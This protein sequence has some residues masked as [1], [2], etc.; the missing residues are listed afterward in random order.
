MTLPFATYIFDLDGTLL[1]TLPDLVVN[2]NTALSQ[3]GF[4]ARTESDI[5]WFIGDGLKALITRC[6]PPGT[7]DDMIEQVLS[8]WKEL[9]PTVGVALAKPYDGIPELLIALQRSGAKLGV[10]SNKF[11]AGVVGL[12]EDHFPG[13]F[14]VVHGEGP[15]IPRKPDPTGLLTTIDELGAEH[16]TTV[17]IGDSPTDVRVAI[18]AGI[19][20][21]AVAWGYHPA[22]ELRDTAAL[23]VVT[24]P[25][26]I[27]EVH[28]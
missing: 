9:Y 4:P 14:T 16:G 6:V 5:H 20:S 7:S 15:S 28:P 21:I 24:D 1:D 26:Q 22:E 27:I 19:T 12:I 8:T 11:E 10:L 3:H 2:T 18:S 13:V 23:A 17:Y 25:I